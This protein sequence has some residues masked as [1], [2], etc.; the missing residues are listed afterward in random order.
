MLAEWESR[1]LE[2]FIRIFNCR[3]KRDLERL[4]RATTLYG[5]D[6]FGLILSAG[7]PTFPYL[8]HSHAAD[9]VPEHLEPSDNDLRTMSTAKVGTMAPEVAKAFGKIDQ[10]FVER[11]QVVGH[12]FHTPNLYTWHFFYFD[13]RDANPRR[14][15]WKGGS[16]IHLINF[17][18]PGRSAESVWR[19]FTDAK[20]E[21]RDSLHVPFV[22][23]ET[24]KF[25]PAS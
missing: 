24:H 1:N 14:N 11:R 22:L 9:F 20:A 21:M 15:H 4:C 8:H 5:H 13:Q 12:M 10:I 18:W 3:R 6:L 19:E 2:G 16:H 7:T 25:T 23:R 17:L